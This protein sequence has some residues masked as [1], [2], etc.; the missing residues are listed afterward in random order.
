MANAELWE[1]VSKEQYHDDPSLSQSALKDYLVDPQF[2]FQRYIAKSIPPKE[3][4]PSQI[5][6][7]A[8]EEV[9]FTG[10]LNAVTIPTEVMQRRNNADGTVTYAKAG[11][12]YNQWLLEQQALHGPGVRVYKEEEFA[13][14]MGPAA[15]LQAVDNLRSH[16]YANR[17]IWG[18]TL[19]SVRIRW[20]DELTGLKC[21]CEIDLLNLLGI[22]GDLKTTRVVTEYGFARVVAQY[23]YDIQAYFYREAL[24]QLAK[25]RDRLPDSPAGRAI[26]PVLDLIAG[27]EKLLCCWVAVKNSPSYHAEVHP[28][29]GGAD[30]NGGWYSIAQ[31][32]VQQAMFAIADAHKTGHWQTRTFGTITNMKPPVFAYNRIQELAGTEE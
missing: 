20:T 7:T 13:K 22:I 25:D 23:G 1:G 30:G 16:N 31:P 18:E 8:V 3:P 2:F 21:R 12:T 27:G 29:D 5:F 4:S 15:I 10:S 26:R 19:R 11:A 14:P 17:L 28:C 9:C 24:Q 32:I 6:G